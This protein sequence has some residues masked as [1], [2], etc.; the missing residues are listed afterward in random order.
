MKFPHVKFVFDTKR[1]VRTFFDFWGEGHDQDIKFLEWAITSKYP[2]FKVCQKSGRRPSLEEV[3]DFVEKFYTE[4]RDEIEKNIAHYEALWQRKEGDFFKLTS[5]L[6]GDQS[7]PKGKYVAFPTMWGMYP[8]FLDDKTFQFPARAKT[9][10]NVVMI[11]AHEM[12]HFIFYSYVGKKHRPLAKDKDLLWHTSE[13]F[14][15]VVMNTSPWWRVFRKKDP[16]YPE[17]SKIIQRL[18]KKYRKGIYGTVAT[19]LL[20]KEIYQEVVKEKLVS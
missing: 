10:A 8:R 14:N 9:G 20:I 1:D 6:F 11:C 19:D 17:H 7:W 2:E 3:R 12:L 18:I 16:G 5:A 4:H 15:S 13:I